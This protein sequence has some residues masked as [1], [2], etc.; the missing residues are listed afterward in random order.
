MTRKFIKR[1][2]K[3][4]FYMDKNQE[5]Y[6]EFSITQKDEGIFFKIKYI[7]YVALVLF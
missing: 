4:K 5:F 3:E 7:R 6:I 1:E 2:I